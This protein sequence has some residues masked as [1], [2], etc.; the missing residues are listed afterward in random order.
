MIN[1]FG[2]ARKSP[3]D[4]KDTESS[5]TNQVSLIESTCKKFGWNLKPENIYIDNNLSGGDR[6]RKEFTHLIKNAIEFKANN[7][8]EDVYIIVKEQ[9]RFARDS[10]FFSDT[11]RDLEIRFIKVFSIIKNNFISYD[12]LGDVVTSVVDAHYIITQRKKSKVLFDQKKE[13]GLP[14]VKAPYGY[15]NVNKK[16]IID[17]KKAEIVRSVFLNSSKKI[18]FKET[19][20]TLKISKALYYRILDNIKKEVYHGYVVY[21][22]KIRDSNKI[23]VREEKIKYKGIHEPILT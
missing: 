13:Q 12:D 2:Y 5:I 11:L 16:W 3:D 22:N 20:N 8:T 1:A 7:P 17:K 10:A 4:K 23:V 14:P 6:S 21:T 15:K 9:D 18:N 19:I